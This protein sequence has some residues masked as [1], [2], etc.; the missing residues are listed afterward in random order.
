MA[1]FKRKSVEAMPEVSEYEFQP[2]TVRQVVVFS[3]W[4][5]GPT[6]VHLEKQDGNFVK[7]TL[8]GEEWFTK[9]V[10]TRKEGDLLIT[11]IR[12]DWK[13]AISGGVLPEGSN[14]YSWAVR[15]FG[16]ATVDFSVK[17]ENFPGDCVHTGPR[18]C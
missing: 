12:D 9:K 18:T 11:S 6:F 7:G 3:S 15:G 4:Q 13:N 1:L 14:V 10:G 8:D 5:E 17:P 2:L 16:F